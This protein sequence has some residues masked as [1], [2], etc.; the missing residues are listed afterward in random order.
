MGDDV[1]SRPEYEL[2]M[3]AGLAEAASLLAAE[4]AA[5][6]VTIERPFNGLRMRARPGATGAQVVVDWYY[7]LGCARETRQRQERDALRARVEAALAQARADQAEAR[8]FLAECHKQ[9]DELEG[10]LS[11]TLAARARAEAEAERLRSAIAETL[12]LADIYAGVAAHNA[13]AEPETAGEAW[14]SPYMAT[15]RELRRALGSV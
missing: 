5:Q 11:D 3:R 13:E 4:A 2:H 15:M 1:V 9:L 7:D 12:R 10:I 6:Q 8:G 14:R